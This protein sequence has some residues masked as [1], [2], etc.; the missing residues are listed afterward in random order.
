MNCAGF[1]PC[2]IAGAIDRIFGLR[3]AIR[4]LADVSEAVMIEK[5]Q[6]FCRLCGYYRP[7][8]ENSRTLLSPT[9][10]ARLES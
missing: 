1:Y 6:I 2:A 8:L 9:W 10:R 5:Y 4:N 7:I 3:E